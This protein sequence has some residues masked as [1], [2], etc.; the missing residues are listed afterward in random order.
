M[1]KNSKIFS[2][3]KKISRKIDS[4]EVADIFLF[5][6]AV[7]GKTKPRDIDV[8]IVFKNSINLKI[9]RQFSKERGAHVSSLTIK[10]FF[11]KPHPLI[12]T[13][14]FEG[15]SLLTGKSLSQN[16]N[17]ESWT[18]FTYNLSKMKPSDKVRFVYL[19]K[20]RG[21]KGFVAEINGKFL[22]PGCF[23]VPTR[24]DDEVIEVMNEWKINFKRQPLLLIH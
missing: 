1:S 16:F 2:K 6:S 11:R 4:E 5:G 21:E 22:A 23:I 18:M 10:D 12:R 20:G 19:L 15:V 3:I 9:V 14:L 17:L 13:L 8:C 24:K 7:K